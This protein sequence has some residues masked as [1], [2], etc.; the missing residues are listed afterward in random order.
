MELMAALYCKKRT[1][2]RCLAIAYKNAI[3]GVGKA[4]EKATELAE[5]ERS[6]YEGTKASG[7]IIR[8]Y[9]LGNLM[10]LKNAWIVA[11]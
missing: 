1:K 5:K 7:N 4:I 2:I 10:L 11:K 8:V 6:A 3:A 9:V